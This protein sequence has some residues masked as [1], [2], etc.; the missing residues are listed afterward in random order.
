MLC[1]AIG[2]IAIHRISTVLK[3]RFQFPQQN[4]LGRLWQEILVQRKLDE[5]CDFGAVRWVI[6]V[7]SIKGST[8]FQ[9]NRILGILVTADTSL[10]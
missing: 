1:K 7:H 3:S 5:E 9:H 4:L 2:T 6:K 10:R 8:W